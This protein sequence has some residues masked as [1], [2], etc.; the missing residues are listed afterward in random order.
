MAQKRPT[1]S[2]LA[3]IVD[4]GFE[5]VGER[6]D[7]IEQKVATVHDYM[8]GQKAITDSKSGSV[9]NKAFSDGS[10]FVQLGCGVRGNTA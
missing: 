7:K 4:R 6:F 3:N 1:N 2:D 9:H 10:L 8:I 5:A